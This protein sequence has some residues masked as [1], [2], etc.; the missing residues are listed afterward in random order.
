MRY[1]TFA[2]G[3]MAALLM[4]GIIGCQSTY[5]RSAGEAQADQETEQ[6]AQAE[7]ASLVSDAR[8]TIENFKRTDPTIQRF[9]DNAYG[10]AVFPN[11]GKGGLIAGGSFGEGVV[12]RQGQP[13]EGDSDR[14][15]PAQGQ[16]AQDALGEVVGYSNIT[17]ATVG[18]QLGGQTFS[19][20]IFFED[21]GTFNRFVQRGE[22][23]SWGPTA[24]ASAV[25][26]TSGAAA[27]SDYSSGVASFIRSKGGLMGEAAVGSQKFSFESAA[28]G[29][30][31][32]VR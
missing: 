21:E 10:Y 19:Q 30:P 14:Y 18:A 7:R 9:F 1:R 24:Q 20:I 27:N 28:G 2:T 29:V 32:Q 22:R 8:A 11:V 17:Q 15:E 26:M 31:A 6:R 3:M 23:G 25:A 16:A 12:F 4:F 13:M 5:K